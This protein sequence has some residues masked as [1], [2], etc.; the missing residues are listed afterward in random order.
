[1]NRKIVCEGRELA[2]D[3]LNAVSGGRGLFDV[4][5]DLQSQD[6]LGNFEIQTLMSDYNQAQALASSV[7]KKLHDT[8]SSIIGKI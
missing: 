2:V 8:N 4:S 7:A 3:E 6:K 5:K 1:M